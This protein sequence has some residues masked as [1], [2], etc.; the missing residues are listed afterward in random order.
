MYK[1]TVYYSGGQSDLSFIKNYM[2]PYWSHSQSIEGN[3][4]NQIAT[5]IMCSSHAYNIDH[6]DV[7]MCMYTDQIALLI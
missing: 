6:F 1:S 7:I 3:D 4:S 5:H 2:L